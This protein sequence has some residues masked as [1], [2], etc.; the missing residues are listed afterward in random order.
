MDDVVIDPDHLCLAQKWHGKN[1]LIYTNVKEIKGISI[2][3]V[4]VA[5]LRRFCVKIE[6]KGQGQV[7][8]TNILKKL[9]DFKTTKQALEELMKK[10]VPFKR[11]Q[12]VNVIFGITVKPL[13][14]TR[15]QTL[16]KKDLTDG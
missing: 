10:K 4:K 8:K 3:D 13:M 5:L 1:K 9:I 2:T 7:S 6:L 11:Y 14:H 12:S 15:G 16:T